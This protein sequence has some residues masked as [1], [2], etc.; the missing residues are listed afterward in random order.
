[1]YTKHISQ[2]LP[3]HINSLSFGAPLPTL[4]KDKFCNVMEYILKPFLKEEEIMTKPMAQ[5]P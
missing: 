1:M 5:I 4:D 2:F 3:T